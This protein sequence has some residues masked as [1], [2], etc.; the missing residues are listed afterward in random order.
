[1]VPL[2]PLH[3]DGLVPKTAFMYGLTQKTVGYRL[4]AILSSVFTLDELRM[5]SIG[6]GERDLTQL[7]PDIV[8]GLVTYCLGCL[9]QGS[10][11]TRVHS[12]ISENCSRLRNEK[13]EASW[14]DSAFLVHLRCFLI[15]WI[16]TTLLRNNKKRKEKRKKRKEKREKKK[17]KNEKSFH[18]PFPLH[19]RQCC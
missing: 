1:M 7:K 17:E 16:L 5:G 15:G 9:G 6:K 13:T 18:S 4:Q 3:P 8:S 10:L 14:N 12:Y 11:Q 19:F 2:S